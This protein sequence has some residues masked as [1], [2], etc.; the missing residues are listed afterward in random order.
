V[1]WPHS[2]IEFERFRVREARLTSLFSSENVLD[3]HGHPA[4]VR[5]TWPRATRGLLQSASRCAPPVA[6]LG[7]SLVAALLWVSPAAALSQ[8]PIGAAAP[9]VAIASRAADSTT[10]LALARR[11]APKRGAK[12]PARSAARPAKAPK[13]APEAAPAKPAKFPAGWPMGPAPLPGAVLP[14]NRI[15]AFYGNPHSKR[16]GIL[17]E[18]E[19]E[20]M[21]ARLEETARQW[22]AADPETPVKPALHLIATVAQGKP[23][24]DNM[25]RMRH[26]TATIDKVAAWAE[27]KG[28]LLFLDI[29]PGHSTVQAEI[30]RLLPYL[31]RPYVHLAL[32]P[33]FS[34]KDGVVPGRK[35]GTMDAADVNH[36]VDVLARLVDSLK[37][38]PKVLV[39]HRFTEA[40]LTNHSRI[41]LDPRVQVVIDMDGF[42]TKPLKRAIYQYVVVEEPVQ[43][44]GFKLFT[45]AKNDKPMMTPAEVLRLSPQPLYIQYQ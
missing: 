36:A 43:F 39:V 7:A 6:P 31:A 38:P 20:T 4:W 30:P 35:I 12:A 37:L 18:L 21:L 11:P 24:S 2:C 40:M 32:D 33:E 45:K 15:V 42:G 3:M 8:A 9:D 41:K 25:Y 22:A 5:E 1:P 23:G 17:G 14:A 34:M 27:R 13:P 16:M 10:K 28:W 19:P 44:S 26:T 29:Q